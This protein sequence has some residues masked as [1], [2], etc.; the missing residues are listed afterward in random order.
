MRYAIFLTITPLQ[1]HPHKFLK[2]PLRLFQRYEGK[3][4]TTSP[5]DI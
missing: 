4:R 3:D 1:K 2:N 5:T